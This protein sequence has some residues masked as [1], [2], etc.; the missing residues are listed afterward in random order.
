MYVDSHVHY[1]HKRFNSV[2]NVLL[3]QLYQNGLEAAVEAAISAE[4][5]LVMQ[6]VLEPYPWMYYSVGLH[7]NCVEAGREKDI[8]Y[9]QVIFEALKNPKVVAVGE[10]G[11]DYHRLRYETDADKLMAQALKRRQEYWFDKLIAL[12]QDRDLPL[13]IHTREA[14]GITLCILQEWTLRKNPGVI[15]CFRGDTFIAKEYLNL[16]FYLGIGG[17]LT[18][19]TEEETREAVKEIPLE[20]ILLETDSPFL[21]PEGS[22]ESKN[23][24]ANIPIVAKL[25]GEL[26]GIS[27][28]EVM[29]VTAENT[30]E[31]FRIEKHN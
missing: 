21:V 7:P 23:T 22:T 25:I 14:H 10:T 28:R 2:R 8:A 3:P 27:A 16:G 4:S 15:H 31:L 11:L 30:R 6:E 13:I 29:E 18:Y 17:A 20:R 9:E 24:S 5:N 19:D 1:A 12:A 26:K